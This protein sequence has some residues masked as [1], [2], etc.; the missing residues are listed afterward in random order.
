MPRDLLS[1]RGL[2]VAIKEAL[3]A[4]AAKNTRVKIR[5][6]DNLMLIVRPGGGASWVLQYRIDGH[7]KPYT[8][9]AW[10]TVTLAHARKLAEKARAQVVEGIDPVQQRQLDR[11]QRQQAAKA[12]ADTV[13]QLFSDW[14]SRQRISEVYRGNIEAAFVKDV[15]PAIGAMT[16]S[17]VTRQHINGILRKLEERDALVMLRR[18]RMWLKQLFE[19]ALDAE[20]VSASPVPTGHLKS[21]RQPVMRHLPAITNAQDVAGLMRAIRGHDKPVVRA[22]LLLSAYT[23]QRPTEVREADWS[24]FDLDAGRWIIPATR[25]KLKREHWVPLAPQVVALLRVHAGVVG[26]C[27]W[28]F[29]GQR[30]G[31]PLSEATLGASLETLGFKGRH[32]PHGFRAMARTILEEHLGVDARY[33]EKQLAHEEADKVKRAYNR[34]EYWAERVKMMSLWADWI[35]SQT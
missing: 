25:M 3:S 34:S 30:Y 35:D 27:G 6:G 24:E 20:R 29:P 21:F 16:P 8:L 17:Q 2:D 11:N 13:R 18:V 22:A 9:G 14:S 12:T 10:P 15:L 32:T 4:A 33:A 23:W 1:A 5:D 7:R 26:D 31:K 19:F 28:L